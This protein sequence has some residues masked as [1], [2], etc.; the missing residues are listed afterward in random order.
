MEAQKKF[1]EWKPEEYVD[2]PVTPAEVLPEDDFRC[3][4]C[5]AVFTEYLL[6]L[7]PPPR[8]ASEA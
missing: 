7:L 1:R 3:N 5:H 8:H 2:R 4:Q 6:P